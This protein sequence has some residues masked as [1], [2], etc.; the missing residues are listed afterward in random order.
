MY[1]EDTLFIKHMHMLQD[2]FKQHIQEVEKYWMLNTVD[3]IRSTSIETRDEKMLL[4]IRLVKLLNGIKGRYRINTRVSKP[5]N[6][7]AYNQAIA[8]ATSFYKK[9]T[10][11]WGKLAELLELLICDI[12]LEL[13]A[14]PNVKILKEL[15]DEKAT[16][17]DKFFEDKFTEGEKKLLSAK[18]EQDNLTG[19]SDLD[20]K[21]KKFSVIISDKTE[22]KIN[23]RADL[24]SMKNVDIKFVL[25]ETDIKEFVTWELQEMY[26]NLEVFE[27][28]SR[29]S[30]LQAILTAALFQ[31]K[32]NKYPALVNKYEFLQEYKS[33]NTK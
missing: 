7:Q 26:M 28:R 11:I 2:A 29:R 4:A 23:E 9:D 3:S 8:N 22:Y 30:V 6:M 24:M 10:I 21:A 5:L 16:N 15:I 25:E 1:I 27:S 33:K 31:Q 20:W 19:S 32:Y 14:K 13:P 18:K 12:E 17:F